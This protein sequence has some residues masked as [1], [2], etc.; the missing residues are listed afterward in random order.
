MSV[1]DDILTEIRGGL[2]RT[3]ELANKTNQPEDLVCKACNRLVVEHVVERASDSDG[4]VYT[5][6][7]H[8]NKRTLR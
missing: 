7:S 6:K 2:T 4:F 3:H 8:W 1:K 5:P